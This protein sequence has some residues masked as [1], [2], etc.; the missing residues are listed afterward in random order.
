MWEFGNLSVSICISLSAG[1]KRAHLLLKQSLSTSLWS[2]EYCQTNILSLRLESCYSFPKIF[3]FHHIA[4][5]LAG[6]SYP[7]RSHIG[8]AWFPM[9]STA[10]SQYIH[11][12]IFL[13]PHNTPPS[14]GQ[15][16]SLP[17]HSK[18]LLISISFSSHQQEPPSSM[19]CSEVLTHPY[20]KAQ[21][22]WLHK[23]LLNW[24]LLLWPGPLLS[25]LVTVFLTSFSY[26][27]IVFSF[28]AGRLHIIVIFFMWP[29][30]YL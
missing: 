13:I 24:V 2:A 25:G 17:E 12:H 23:D 20:R 30:S 19:T 26:F 18:V 15:V 27:H 4:L 21:W 1:E 14:S 16:L 6:N 5:L 22:Y 3:H 9:P 7:S 11:P 29:H 8:V 10:L 28:T